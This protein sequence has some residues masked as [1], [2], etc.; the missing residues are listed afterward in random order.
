MISPLTT[1]LAVYL[2]AI[3][4]VTFAAFGID[5]RRARRSAWRIQESTLLGLSAAGG[6]VGA[7]AGMRFFRH[8]TRKPKFTLGVP[9]TALAWIV[10]TILLWRS[11]RL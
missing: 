5:K 9:L 4:A 1:L 11:G 8:K 10:A 3:N 6:F 7:L 2:L